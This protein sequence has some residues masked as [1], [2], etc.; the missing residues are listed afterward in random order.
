[1]FLRLISEADAAIDR[2]N[3]GGNLSEQKGCI[4]CERYRLQVEG[5]TGGAAGM[6]FKAS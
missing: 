1:M 2:T 5:G 3:P 6:L 4:L